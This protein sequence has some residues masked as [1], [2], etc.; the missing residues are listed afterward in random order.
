MHSCEKH[1]KLKLQ[2]S[3]F[4]IY[5]NLLEEDSG[6]FISRSNEHTG[7][8]IFRFKDVIERLTNQCVSQIV[9]QKL[10]SKAARVFR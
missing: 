10:G 9:D 7:A 1:R 6:H 8:I 4:I 3:V 2:Y 5:L